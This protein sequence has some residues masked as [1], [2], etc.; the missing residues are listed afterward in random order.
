MWILLGV[1]VL[2]VGQPGEAGTGDHAQKVSHR[3]SRAATVD[4]YVAIGDSYTAGSG[5][6]PGV[7]AG[8][9]RSDRS[10]PHRLADR[11]GG[12]V[13]DVSCAGATTAHAET[14]QPTDTGANPPQL[15]ALD[16]ADR[17]GDGEPGRQRRRVRALVSGC[18]EVAPGTR[19]ARRAARRTRARA[20][21]AP[22][23]SP[24]SGRG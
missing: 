14:A 21:S 22:T 8:C 15:T 6:P 17:P 3:E 23:S 19:S 20:T 9:W 11:L 10:Y 2:L 18:P 4:R 7:G 24:R 1:F 13:V 16:R 5:I 12:R